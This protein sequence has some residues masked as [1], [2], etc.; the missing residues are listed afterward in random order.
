MPL[1]HVLQVQGAIQASV[2]CFVA[3]CMFPLVVAGA[4]LTLLAS[5]MVHYLMSGY[6]VFNDGVSQPSTHAA[7]YA[8]PRRFRWARVPGGLTSAWDSD[9]SSSSDEE[10]Q[11]T[12]S[13]ASRRVHRLRTRIGARMTDLHRRL[14]GRRHASPDGSTGEGPDSSDT[15]GSNRLRQ[16]PRHSQAWAARMRRMRSTFQASVGSLRR[17][18]S[19]NSSSESEPPSPSGFALPQRKSVKDLLQ[20]VLKD[21]GFL[22]GL[23]SELPGV[24]V[25][26]VPIQ[27]AIERMRDDSMRG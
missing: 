18:A 27:N 8:P 1:P 19:Y 3:V 22:Y 20:L 12:S 9:Y 25:T 7:E 14:A 17:T 5:V 24:D 21:E 23:L 26:S 4:V 15:E 13:R 10:D 11:G 16:T 6:N 2:I